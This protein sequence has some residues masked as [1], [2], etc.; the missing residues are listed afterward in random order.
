[1]YND[2]IA[3]NNNIQLEEVKYT[4]FKLT[5]PFLECNL[6]KNRLLTLYKALETQVISDK[7]S[8]TGKRKV[9]R[10]SSKYCYRC[11]EDGKRRNPGCHRN[12]FKE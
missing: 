10:S 11:F 8:G 2:R 9:C 12:H 5:E 6:L 3:N 1:M 7:T 4:Y